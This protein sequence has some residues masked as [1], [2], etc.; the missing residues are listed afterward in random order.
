MEIILNN[1][2]EKIETEKS[3][4]TVSE[5]LDIKNFTFELLI[6]RINGELVKQ[7]NYSTSTF[8]NGD[9]VDV[10]HVFGGG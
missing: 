9:K 6:V 8:T 7:A 5:L 10:I 2:A 3:L 1:A 4:L